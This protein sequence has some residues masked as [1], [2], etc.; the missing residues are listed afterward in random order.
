MSEPNPRESD[1]VL[2]G[3]NPPPTNA[4]IL[5]GLAGVK[6]RLASES[7]VQRLQALN[8]TVQYGGNAIDLLIQALSDSAD[9][10]C[11]LAYKLL[12]DR[13]N[14]SE[15]DKLFRSLAINNDSK[16]RLLGEIARYNDND[17]ITSKNLAGNPNTPPDILYKLGDFDNM[18]KV[19]TKSIH[20][21]S[22]VKQ[23]L[24]LNPSR[25]GNYFCCHGV[26]YLE[27]HYQK[28]IESDISN[29][30]VEIIKVACN[31]YRD[32]AK[33]PNSPIQLLLHLG[34]LFPGDFINNPILPHLIRENPKFIDEGYDL[35][36]VIAEYPDTPVD[37]LQYLLEFGRHGVRKNI[38][39]H[40]NIS[41]EMLESMANYAIEQYVGNDE[42]P[43]GIAKNSK[44]PTHVLEKLAVYRENII[45]DTIWFRDDKERIKYQLG[46]AIADHPNTPEELR[47]KMPPVSTNIFW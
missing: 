6:Q 38:A 35:Q 30:V 41:L 3:Q 9:E 42:T 26:V 46:R 11:Q 27:A 44:T 47:C 12:C 17:L 37:I 24:R 25:F 39:I 5:G 1:L 23:K 40:P 34:R 10:V 19:L 43:V 2:G 22:K 16:P 8:D 4:A 15:R 29:E 32:L 18:E 31:I 20:E 21:W 33:N 28:I 36:V 13:S 45:T 7:I 14:K